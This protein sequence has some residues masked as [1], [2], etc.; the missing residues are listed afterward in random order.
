[1][2]L[3]ATR[4]DEVVKERRVVLPVLGLMLDHAVLADGAAKIGE[5]QDALQAHAARREHLGGDP[6]L[7]RLLPVDVVHARVLR[8]PGLEALDLDVAVVHEIAA[9]HAPAR[10]KPAAKRVTAD[11]GPETGGDDED[12]QRWK[13]GEE[14]WHRVN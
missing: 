14:L 9:G 3:P 10:L 7:G 13:R 8:V 4:R 11:V 5:E 12:E 2:H 6:L 1:A